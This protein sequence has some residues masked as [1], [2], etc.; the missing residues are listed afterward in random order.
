MHQTNRYGS[1][2]AL[3]LHATNH[4]SADQASHDTCTVFL[5]Y[6]VCVCVSMTNIDF[7]WEVGT[8]VEDLHEFVVVFELESD[9]LSLTITLELHVD[10]VNKTEELG[11]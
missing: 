10:V 9:A 7:P 4:A 6:W 11:G 8:L 3:A 1:L 2:R 5:Q